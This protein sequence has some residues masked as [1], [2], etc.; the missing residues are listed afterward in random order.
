M[1]GRST[2]ELTWAIQVNHSIKNS[3]HEAVTPRSH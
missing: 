1:C 2:N 3:R